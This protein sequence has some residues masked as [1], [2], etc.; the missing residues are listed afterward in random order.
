MY[1]SDSVHAGLVHS[2]TLSG[3]TLDAN[4][5]KRELLY[6][7]KEESRARTFLEH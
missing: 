4:T 3:Q 2:R 1:A 7:Q 6:S 5:T